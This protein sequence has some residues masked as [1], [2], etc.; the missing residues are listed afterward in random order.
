MSPDL[1]GIAIESLVAVLLIITIGYCF[2]LNQRLLRLKADEVAFKATIGELI[3]ATEIAERA[4]GGLK[5]AVTECEQALGQ[6]MRAAEGASTELAGQ[7]GSAQTVLNRIALITD[8]ARKHSALA[9]EQVHMGHPMHHPAYAE[10]HHLMP[11][12]A[13]P[14]HA[15]SYAAAEP[16]YAAN[17]PGHAPAYQ[18]GPQGYPQPTPYGQPGAQARAASAAAETLAARARMRARGEAA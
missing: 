17:Y 3:A 5:H 9:Q 12:Y 15:P 11:V 13:E 7:V 1:V 6:R 18:P 2:V 8:A 4:I 16:A 10:P 14:M